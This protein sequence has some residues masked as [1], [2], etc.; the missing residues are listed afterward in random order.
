M[1]IVRLK[2]TVCAALTTGLVLLGATVRPPA[3][4]ALPEADVR[5]KLDTILLLMVVDE[6]GQPRPLKLNLDE[7]SVNGYLGTISI[8]AAEEITAGQRYGLSKEDA[9]SLRFTPVSLARF[10]QLLEPLL[11][12]KPS[13]VGVIAPD[14]TQ[15]ATAETLL[16]AQKVPAAQAKQ[17]AVLQPLV[18]CPEPG[19]LVSHKDGEGKSASF[20]PCATEADFVQTI[21]ERAI[22][23]SAKIAASK[24]RVVA[25]PLN[26]FVA[27][28]RSATPAQAG[29]IRVVP[30][31]RIVSLIQAIN[32]QT[33]AQQKNAESTAKPTSKT[34]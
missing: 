9:K 22:K 29:E 32:Q 16:T 14:P 15:M 2:S 3:A 6:K 26:S 11:K 4:R 23:E 21:V 34:R 33:K 18:F 19:L 12:A 5:A 17:I 10:N 20:I 30:S 27:Y 13:E 7:R 31:G 8:S 25:I 1:R 28:L 24:P